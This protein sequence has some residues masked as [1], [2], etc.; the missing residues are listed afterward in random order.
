MITNLI[1]EICWSSEKLSDM[2]K[3]T[4]ITNYRE[5]ILTHVQFQGQEPELRCRIIS[6]TL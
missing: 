1:D 3:V 5:E 6:Q 4:E 2:P